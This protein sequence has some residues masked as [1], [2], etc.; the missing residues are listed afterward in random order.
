MTG[1]DKQFLWNLMPEWVKESAVGLDPTM[2]GTGTYEGDCAIR[3]RVQEILGINPDE[4]P[5]VPGFH[6]DEKGWIG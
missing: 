4:M 5:D 2:Y 1:D 3:L 6:P